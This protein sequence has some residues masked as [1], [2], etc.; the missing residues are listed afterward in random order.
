MPALPRFPDQ[1]WQIARPQP[2]QTHQLSQL[3]Q[4]HPLLAQ[5]LLNRGIDTPEATKIFLDPEL[6]LLPSPL[7][8]FEDL[9]IALE[10]LLRAIAERQFIAICGDYDADGMTS[11]ALLLRALRFLGAIVDYAIP[12]RMQEGYGINRRIVEEFHDEGVGLILTVD[13]GIAAYDPIARARELGMAIIVTDHHD[14]PPTL[15]PAN[16]ILNPKLIRETSPYRGIAGVGVAYILAVCL[17]QSLQKT[18]DLTTPLIELFTLG[19]IADLAPLTGV[20]RR[21]VKRGLKLLPKSRIAGVQALIQVAGLSNET[22]LKPEAI[23]FRLG[24]RIN[25]IG[26]ISDPQIVIELLTT[27]EDGRAL[28]LAMKCEQVNQLRQRLCELIEQEAIAWCEETGFN[29]QQSR[30]LVIVQPDWHHG[31]IGIVASRLVE[32]YGV[33]VFIGTY[34]EEAEISGE[35]G[36]VEAEK[37]PEPLA[38]NQRVQGPSARKIRGSARGIPEFDVFEALCFCGDVLQKFGG[39]KAAGGFTL[40]AENLDA[41]RTR[42]EQFAHQ[43]LRPDQL[44]PLVNVDV[45]ANFRDLT[46][47]LYHQLDVLHPCGIENADPVFWTANVHIV[48]QRTVGRD[49]AHLKLTLAQIEDPS[50]SLRAVAWRWG[51][52]YPLP[53]RVD[54]AYR[55]RLNEWN[56][57]RSVEL[58]LIGIRPT[59]NSGTAEQ[60]IARQQFQPNERPTASPVA[61]LQI[62]QSPSSPSQLQAQIFQSVSRPSLSRSQPQT[63]QTPISHAPIQPWP[64]LSAGLPM[65]SPSV[66][67]PSVA[68]VSSSVSS[69]PQGLRHSLNSASG[70][71]ETIADE[72][73]CFEVASFFR[74]GQSSLHQIEF[75]YDKC[76]YTG[77]V[78]QNGTAR[79]LR[80]QNLEGQLLIIQPEQRRGFWGYEGKIAEAIDVSQPYYFNLVRSALMALELAEKNQLIQ[81]QAEQLATKEQQIAQLMQRLN[82]L[83]QELNTAQSIIQDTEQGENCHT[84]KDENQNECIK[85]PVETKSIEQATQLETAV[86]QCAETEA[87]VTVDALEAG[88]ETNS[89]DP[90]QAIFADL[91]ATSLA[92]LPAPPTELPADPKQRAKL[93]LGEVWNRLDSRSQKDLTAAY[94]K[95]AALQTESIAEDIADGENP[96]DYSDVGLRLCSV[97][98]REVVQ[99]CFKTLHQ[100]LL[101]HDEPCEIGGVTLRARKKYTVGML[102]PLLAAEWQT[103]QEDA[104]TGRTRLTADN[105]YTSVTAN[106]VEPADRDTIQIFL[107]QWEHPLAI[108]LQ[109]SNA[110]SAIAQIDRLLTIAADAEN[111]LYEWQLELLETLILGNATQLGILDQIY[112]S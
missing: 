85:K 50:I 53:D 12:S 34:E 6:Q 92:P 39:H 47:D 111:L 107:S 17:A 108:W 52:Y 20:N 71:A 88:I 80:I 32:R 74:A 36:E 64:G 29:P 82:Q 99:P 104:L 93:K 68:S 61:Q 75:Y 14:I 51:S 31:V 106:S 89:T 40:A 59:A 7:D 54:V 11:T 91:S 76:K 49:Q 22:I 44:K 37:S 69:T 77:G 95:L 67:S 28:E 90:L 23:G 8:E 19:T 58:E 94:K 46:L 26:R 65:S 73:A 78:Y 56:G 109:S 102:P 72:L 18:Q 43:S 60:P 101:E 10:L 38:A 110:A 79:E 42:L 97:I 63:F 45:E 30:V 41:F 1:R 2:E 83:Q 57:V 62:P 55:L 25:A 70:L 9:P 84:N 4:L 35:V 33:P 5:I 3:F 66:S 48:E 16:A 21:W 100:F 98:E 24:P 13:N 96:I 15:P 112:S 105:L 87:E 103:F 81:E 86:E 27:D